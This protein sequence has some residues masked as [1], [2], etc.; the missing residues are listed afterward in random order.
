MNNHVTHQ[1]GA[2]MSRG[3]LAR[4]LYR[5]KG[6]RPSAFDC[7]FLQMPSGNLVQETVGRYEQP[8]TPR[9]AAM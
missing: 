9:S 6:P 1:N 5:L 7:A 4:S 3:G 2:L 8:P